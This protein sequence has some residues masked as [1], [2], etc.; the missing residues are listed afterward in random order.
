MKVIYHSVGES[1]NY[2]KKVPDE[3]FDTDNVEVQ[4]QIRDYINPLIKGE[5][6]IRRKPDG[7]PDYEIL[8]RDFYPSKED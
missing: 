8:Y 3:W 2:E 5:V 6:A 1:A 7:S 4:K